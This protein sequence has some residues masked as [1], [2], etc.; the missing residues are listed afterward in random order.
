M[1]SRRNEM[2]ARRREHD[3]NRSTLRQVVVLAAGE[4]RTVVDTKVWPCHRGCTVSTSAAALV[5][6]RRWRRS[7]TGGEQ[8]W[9][10]RC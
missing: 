5:R 8:G 6:L 2:L 4:A 9:H 10:G 7:G 3:Q 1:N